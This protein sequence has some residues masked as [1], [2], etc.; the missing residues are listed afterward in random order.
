[1]EKELNRKIHNLLETSEKYMRAIKEIEVSNISL[2]SKKLLFSLLKTQSK[3]CNKNVIKLM[4]D[5]NK[6]PLDV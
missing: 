3:D 5:K 6:M 2:D 1:M 4:A